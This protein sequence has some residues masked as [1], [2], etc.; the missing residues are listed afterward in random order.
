MRNRENLFLDNIFSVRKNPITPEE[1]SSLSGTNVTVLDVGLLD[2]YYRF[3]L[4]EITIPN[5]NEKQNYT[6]DYYGRQS[7]KQCIELLNN[8]VLYLGKQVNHLSE[9]LFLN[10]PKNDKI[11]NMSI[12][13]NKFLD[14]IKILANQRKIYDF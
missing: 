13:K 8:N 7:K 9:I 14:G 2:D 12:H 10:K 5:K 11:H 1:L 3:Y 6:V 4:V